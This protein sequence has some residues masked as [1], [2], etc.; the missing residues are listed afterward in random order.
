MTSVEKRR[1]GRK[2]G[3]HR[4]HSDASSSGSFLDETD[5]E[6]SSLTDRAFRSLCIGDEAIYNDSDLCTSSPCSQRDIQ[7]AWGQSV[8]HG[9]IE[10]REELKRAAHESFSL[11]MQQYGQDLIHGGLYGAQVHGEPQWEVYGERTQVSATFQQSFVETSRQEESLGDE[12]LLFLSNGAKELSVQQRRSRS[13]VSSLIQAFNSE[14]YAD[15]GGMDGQLRERNDEA[16]WDRSALMGVPRDMS[17]YQQNHYGGHFP[18][19][20]AYSSRDAG[21]YSAMSHVNCQASFMRSSHSKHSVAAHANSNFFMH[22]EFSPFKVWKDHNRFPFQQGEVSGYMQRSEFSKWYETPMYKSISLESGTQGQYGFDEGGLRHARNNLAPAIPALP[23]RSTS[24]SAMPPALTVEKRCES[25]L[26]V[27]YPH[28]KRTE[29]LRGNRFPS[30]RPSTASPTAEMSRRVQDTISSVKALQHKIKMM[31]EQNLTTAMPANNLDVLQGNNGLFPYGSGTISAGPAGGNTHTTTFNTGQVCA[32]LVYPHHHDTETVAA[33]QQLRAVSPELVEHAPVRAESRGATP[34]VRISSYRS[35]A[36]SLLFNLKDNRKRVKSTYSPTKF[37]GLEA[38]EKSRQHSTANEAQDTVIDIPQCSD[39]VSQFTE[40][41]E[42]SRIQS[43]SHQHA[44]LYDRTGFSKAA[45]YSQPAMDHIDYPESTADHY[46]AALT[47]SEMADYSGY[48]GFV[49]GNCS[50]NQLANGQNLQ[51]D[52]SSFTPYRQRI[53][54]QAAVSDAY[55]PKTRHTAREMPRFSSEN[56][57]TGEYL[58]SRASAKQQFNETA[59]KELTRVDKYQPLQEHRHYYSNVSSQDRWRQTNNQDT[60]NI[61]RKAATTPWKQEALKGDS[62]QVQAYQKEAAVKNEPNF[63]SDKYRADDQPSQST[64]QQ[65]AVLKQSV[66]DGT[67]SSKNAALVNPNSLNQLPQYVPLGNNAVETPVFYGQ[68]LATLFEDTYTAQKSRNDEQNKM[69]INNQAKS[70]QGLDQEP[71]KQPNIHSKK[72]KI[73]L[74]PETGHTRLQPTEGEPL[75]ENNMQK[76]SPFSPEDTQTLTGARKIESTQ[77]VEVKGSDS[78]EPIKEQHTQAELARPHNRAQVELPRATSDRLILA[79]Q[80]SSEK[81]KAEHANVKPAELEK[82]VPDK[83]EIIKNKIPKEKPAEQIG[84]ATVQ[85]NTEKRMAHQAAVEVKNIN[86]ETGFKHER[87]ARGEQVKAEPARAERLK[88]EHIKSELVETEQTKIKHDKSQEAG[89]EQIRPEQLVEE[90]VRKQAEKLDLVKPEHSEVKRKQAEEVEM[91]E[92]NTHNQQKENKKIRN[93][94]NVK[95]EKKQAEQKNT[96][97][98]EKQQVMSGNKQE[99]S[100]NSAETVKHARNE[101]DK[102]ERVKTELA[103]AKAELAKIKEKLRGDHRDSSIIPAKVE[104]NKNDVRSSENVTIGKEEEEAMPK[105]RQRQESVAVSRQ[106]VTQADRGGD[107]YERLREKYGF[108]DYTSTNRQKLSAERKASSNNDDETQTPSENRVETVKDDKSKPQNDPE[109]TSS[110]AKRENTEDVGTLK[111]NEVK[112][113][114]DG[115]SESSKEFKSSR[116]DYSSTIAKS[117]NS[118][119]GSDRVKKGHSENVE[120]CNPPKQIDI[121]KH[122]DL[123]QA[124]SL[125]A[126]RKSKSSEPT[127]ANSTDQQ[128]APSR[129][130][131]HKERAQTKQ[132]ILTSKIKAHAEKEISA[133][134][135]SAIRDGLISKNFIKPLAGSQRPEVQMPPVQEASNKVENAIPSKT[136]PNLQMEAVKFVSP[137]TSVTMPLKPA[138]I[139]GQLK[140]KTKVPT[141]AREE[142]RMGMTSIKTQE[143]LA[144]NHIKEKTFELKQTEEAIQSKQEHCTKNTSNHIRNDSSVQGHEKIDVSENMQGKD[145]VVNEDSEPS[146]QLVFGRTD[147]GVSEDSLQ[148]MGIMVTVHERKQSLDNNLSTGEQTNPGGQD[149]NSPLANTILQLSQEKESS[150]DVATIKDEPTDAQSFCDVQ[151]SS[152]QATRQNTDL[153]TDG[154]VSVKQDKVGQDGVKMINEE[155]SSQKTFSSENSLAKTVQSARVTAQPAITDDTE[156][157]MKLDTTVAINPS[158]HS[159]ISVTDSPAVERSRDDQMQTSPN[160]THQIVERKNTNMSPRPQHKDARTEEN[161]EEQ[162]VHIDNIAIRV[163]QTVTKEDNKLVEKRSDGAALSDVVGDGGN[164]QAATSHLVENERE[165]IIE[166]LTPAG[167]QSSRNNIPTEMAMNCDDTAGKSE[168]L[169][170]ELQQME[171]NYFHIQSTEEANKQAQTSVKVRDRCDVSDPTRSNKELCSESCSENK[172]EVFGLEQSENRR[173]DSSS[174]LLQKDVQEE[175]IVKTQH[176]EVDSPAMRQC[177]GSNKTDVDQSAHVTKQPPEGQPATLARE[178]QRTQSTRQTVFQDKPEVKP[179]TKERTSTIPE[180]SAIADYARLK[181]IVSDDRDN[182]IQEFPPNKKEGFFPLIQSRHS[183]RPAYTADPHTVS[184]KEEK[185]LPK[186]TEVGSKV[187]KEPKPL[188]FPITEK[189]HQRTGMFKLGDKE[190]QEKIKHEK[191]S[192]SWSKQVEHLQEGNKPASVYQSNIPSAQTT[193]SSSANRTEQTFASQPKQVDKSD[194]SEKIAEVISHDEGMPY[195]DQISK[196]QMHDVAENK[197]LTPGK[198]DNIHNEQNHMETNKLERED[199][200]STQRAVAEANIQIKQRLEES[201]ASLAEE[202]R[203]A[204]QREVERRAQEREAIANKIKERRQKQREAER[205]AEEE[206]TAKQKEEETKNKIEGERLA[207]QWQEGVQKIEESTGKK[208]QQ[209]EV[210]VHKRQ[211]QAAEEEQ[212]RRAGQGKHQRGRSPDQQNRRE[213]VF[214]V[215]RGVAHG[216]EQRNRVV[217]QDEL[218]RRATQEEELKTRVTLEGQRRTAQDKWQT[219][220]AQAEQQRRA[221]AVKQQRGAAQEE[222]NQG[223]ALREKGLQRRLA[224]EEEVQ[225][226]AAQEEMERRKASQDMEQLRRAAEIQ[227]QQ[228]RL[229]AQE[230]QQRRA[231]REEEQKRRAAAEE[232]QRRAAREEQLRRAAQEEE[233]LRRAAQEEEQRRRAANEEQLRKAAQKEE[234]RAAR[235]E[236]QKRRAAQEEEQRRRFALEEQLRKEEHQRMLAAEEQ[237]RKATQEKEIQIKAAQKEE[238]MRRATQ[239]E[240]LKRAAQEEELRRRS[241]EEKLVRDDQQRRVALIEEQQK[242]A[243]QDEQQTT[244]T[245]LEAKLQTNV[246]VDEKNK[247]NQREE[248]SIQNLEERLTGDSKMK[249]DQETKEQRDMRPSGE[250]RIKTH[251]D[252]ENRRAVQKEKDIKTNKTLG[253]AEQKQV[254]QAEGD[255]APELVS[256][257]REAK[258]KTQ[259]AEEDKERT[260]VHRT[261]EQRRAAQMVDALQYYTIASESDRK[262]R[263]RQRHSS[264]PPTRRTSSTVLEAPEDPHHRPSRPSAPASPAIPL[265]RSNTSSPAVGS[266]P[267]MFLV[268]DNT[269]RGSSFLK[270]VKPRFHKNF[271]EDFRVGSPAWSETGEEEQ[272]A[273]R[274]RATTPLHQDSGPNRL[275]AIRESST[276]QPWQDATVPLPHHQ[277]HH[278]RPFS[279]RSLALDEDDSRSVVS[280]MSEDV[281]SFATSAADLSDIRSLYDYER[282]ESSCSFSSDVCRSMGKPPAVPPKSEKAL[283]RAQ[284]LTTRRIKKELSR[285]VEDATAGVEKPPQEDSRIPSS[286]GTEV[287]SPG[288]CAVATP[289]FSSPVSLAHTP[290]GESALLLSRAERQPPH[291]SG[292]AAPHPADSIT[293]PAAAVS[294][295]VAS[296]AAIATAAAAPKIVADVP[297]S[298]T[299]HRTSHPAPVTKYHVESGYPGSYPVTQRK[300]LQD[301]GS[302]QYFVVDVP[303]PVKTKTFIDPQTGKYVQLNVRESTDRGSQ[304]Q[305]TYLKPLASVAPQQQP[306]SQDFPAGKNLEL[307]QG[308]NGYPANVNNGPHNKQSIPVTPYQ[309]QQPDRGS[310]TY[311][312]PASGRVQ[313]TEGHYGSPERT[314]Y[315]DTVSAAHKAHNPVSNAHSQYESFPE[316]DTN[317]HHLARSPALRNVNSGSSQCQ[318]R[319]IKTMSELEDFM[320]LSDW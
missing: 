307:Y 26:A 78:R 260:A 60:E 314:P 1:S 92:Q 243:A 172:K 244:S 22:S 108:T 103:K 111:T 151:E 152:A 217:S 284:R 308:Y 11:R 291:S 80:A 157:S 204:T 174:V 187:N 171:E 170:S 228:L 304:L 77:F 96:E 318:P 51:E 257:Q 69:T 292:Y 161:L 138:E 285:A 13:R 176:I 129:P 167:S 28:R 278:H 303:V 163:V 235:E 49:P 158:A 249:A 29:S 200:A 216:Q 115:C 218:Q 251:R 37:K 48:T 306:I 36:T 316:F 25:E 125:N 58:I 105:Y 85:L 119:S 159:S 146:L 101:P 283:R 132:E 74:A 210:E 297:S 6:V 160:H 207:R 184:A 223:E 188:V 150:T 302:G 193:T 195:F 32:P 122:R 41:E 142:N 214:G 281:E 241:A 211:L 234:Q 97:L 213:T 183:R 232:Q 135:G 277:H 149:G 286:S 76:R 290:K 208:Q 53:T 252:E 179:R 166:N 253:T 164:K 197:E 68:Q 109:N 154:Q 239:N 117:E 126:E 75:L 255:T 282:P 301:V 110:A 91:H 287:H 220:A 250:A 221:V 215:Q 72:E 95:D 275:A 90:L 185:S 35:R 136:I 17:E 93:E 259:A 112:D 2:S 128:V 315:M 240:K 276:P 20:S 56:N 79:E 254:M 131:T 102:V 104:K 212:E 173:L 168:K 3:K 245:W 295:P 269:S 274:Q 305:Q 10:D 319:D 116:V 120:K 186:K 46:H 64:G 15:G 134:K 67:S 83:T 267:S 99:T 165:D 279:R 224:Q 47:Q 199:R 33:Q 87:E 288:R 201:R 169:K 86:V 21:V 227:E 124:K 45:A 137:Q 39:T 202:A 114:H 8:P 299:L 177:N 262:G 118:D 293:L 65:K 106:S 219:E 196:P 273:I 192:D 4:K 133:I 145:E 70:N 312:H 246:D 226:R 54:D 123:D 236:E 144:E 113:N 42:F 18:P 143:A 162:C 258:M 222:E 5:R 19:G 198:N 63:R 248:G 247:R 153:W 209:Q 130:L 16:A 44:S 265:P 266:K 98:T 242:R 238:Q 270:S 27:Q 203:R 175:N 38:A 272:E 61:G 34:D 43:A 100:E 82:I 71:G 148:I 230:E 206:R 81:V 23:L 261:K 268:K 52:L 280:Y 50:S 121:S 31:S 178:R 309:S 40:A 189:E 271:G 141:K 263:E 139:T 180:I 84:L 298:P 181:V 73:P 66:P 140:T 289:H 311:R 62:S 194:P 14:G 320:E 313:H 94:Q 156:S 147:T 294:L 229:A 191:A 9:V 296:P 205:K 88:E 55:A 317:S 237:Q 24:T 233:K 310:R 12:Q 107:D 59:G 155:A 231:V 127:S 190:K 256:T 7:R 57:P 225:K 182:T 300:V 264:P 30:Q 89:A